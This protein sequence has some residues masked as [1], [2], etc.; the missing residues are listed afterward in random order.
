MSNFPTLEPAFTIRVAI[1]A[2]LSVGSSSRGTPLAVVPMTGGT[3]KSESGFSPALDATFKGVGNDFIHNDP[4]GKHMRLNAHGVLE[5]ATI[6]EYV[7]RDNAFGSADF[8]AI[9]D[10][11]RRGVYQRPRLQQQMADGF[12]S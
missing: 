9:Q 7:S 12:S 8:G 4:T 6:H 1:D 5:Y 11:R 3:V 2:P 10:I